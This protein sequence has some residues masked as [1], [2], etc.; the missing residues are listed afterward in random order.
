MGVSLSI[1]ALFA[2]GVGDPEAAALPGPAP[3]ELPP[4]PAGS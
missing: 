4:L 1:S 3:A 2:A